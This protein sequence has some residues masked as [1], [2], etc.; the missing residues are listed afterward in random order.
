MIDLN[1][2]LVPDPDPARTA[3]ETQRL[4]IEEGRAAYRAGIGADRC[5]R[6]KDPDM[7]IDWA[8]GHRWE[9]EGA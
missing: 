5:L 6:F 1:A 8:N 4:V 2:P 9:R 3:K 7:R